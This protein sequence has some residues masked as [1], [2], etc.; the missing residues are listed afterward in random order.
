[1]QGDLRKTLTLI[2]QQ[3]SNAR[4]NPTADDITQASRSATRLMKA[5][6]RR[7]GFNEL[8]DFVHPSHSASYKPSTLFALFNVPNAVWRLT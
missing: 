7:V 2:I 8:L 6:L 4:I 1:M 5:K 3:E